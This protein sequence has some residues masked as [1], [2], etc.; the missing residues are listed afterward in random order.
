MNLR[1][2]IS[3]KSNNNKG[4]GE[5]GSVPIKKQKS[6]ATELSVTWIIQGIFNPLWSYVWFTCGITF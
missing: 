1:K 3:T 2:Q 5:S 6:S 4:S